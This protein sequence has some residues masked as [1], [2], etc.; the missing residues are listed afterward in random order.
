MASCMI[1]KDD[2]D[3]LNFV[4]DD[5]FKT[6]TLMEIYNET[7][8]T[9]INILLKVAKEK[10]PDCLDGRRPPIYVVTAAGRAFDRGDGVWE[11]PEYFIGGWMGNGIF[12]MKDGAVH[13]A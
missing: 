4:H 7:K 10:Y 2:Q 3:F 6:A 13:P 8:S 5:R 9:D 1:K 12:V 11:K